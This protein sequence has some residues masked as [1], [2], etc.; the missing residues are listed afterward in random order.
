MNNEWLHDA[1]KIPDEVMAYIRKIAVCSV[2]ERRFSPDAVASFLGISRAPIY[3]WLK[4]YNQGGYD[5]LESRSA[6]GA[7]PQIT[8]DIDIWLQEVVLHGSPSA[9]GYDTDLWTRRMLSEMLQKEFGVTVGPSAVGAHLARL[10]LSYQKPQYVARERDPVE[11][12]RFLNIKFPLI[13]RVANKLGAEIAFEDESG[14]DVTDRSGR[15]WGL[16]GHTPVVQA[17]GHR[18]RVNIF[19]M[20]TRDGLLKYEIT[21][22]IIDSDAYIGFL[23]SILK[24]REHPIVLL[25]D[26]ARFH[27]SRAVRAFVREHRTRIR[28]FFLPR[29]SPEYNPAEQVWEEIKDNKIGRQ[30]IYSKKDLKS[31]LES[32]LKS[33]ALDTR[34][35]M[36]FFGL[37][38]TEYAIS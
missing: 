26:R 5:A 32:A 36:S 21:E 17:S 38:T 28:V 6:P 3:Q 18:G 35:I 2:I 34:R 19:S 1:R 22:A 10:G 12:E 14:I 23:E 27:N 16:V 24:D 11:I 4:W 25:M 31:K 8:P 15:T 7:A 33:L 20:V 13:Q 37:S 29:Y 9:Y 30:P